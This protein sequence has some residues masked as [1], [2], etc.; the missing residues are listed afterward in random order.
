MTEVLLII[1]FLLVN[2]IDTITTLQAMKTGLSEHN[3]ILASIIEKLGSK[4][5]IWSKFITSILFIFI[6][7]ELSI[8]SLV[9]VCLIYMLVV[10]NNIRALKYGRD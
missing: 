5:F 4:G 1:V 2:Y 7:L 9:I 10:V 6:A 3:P 8:D